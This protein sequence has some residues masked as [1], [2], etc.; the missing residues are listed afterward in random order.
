M[1]VAPFV[2]G[3]LTLLCAD[4]AFA[5]PAP[6]VIRA[7]QRACGSAAA[8]SSVGGPWPQGNAAFSAAVFWREGAPHACLAMVSQRANSVAVVARGS[9]DAGWSERYHE[10]FEPTLSPEPA[11]LA[12]RAPLPVTTTM[13]MG[14]NGSGGDL[15]TLWISRAG[16]WRVAYAQTLTVASDINAAVESPCE[17]E[18]YFDV[19]GAEL[20]SSECRD[21]KRDERVLR[22]DG[23][24]FVE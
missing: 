6:S 13:E 9:I 17:T 12:G 3:L 19:H 24:R 1:R 11:W 21:G 20:V 4:A 18:G 22:F 14:G 16:R 2:L 10:R 5:Q 23:R 15:T 7:L 8:P